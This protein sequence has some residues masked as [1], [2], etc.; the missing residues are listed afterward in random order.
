M[1]RLRTVPVL[2]DVV[3]TFFS[4]T[5]VLTPHGQLLDCASIAFSERYVSALSYVICML[6]L[7]P[8]FY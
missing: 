2:S 1:F 5:V 8:S 3:V 4:S 6:L 7:Y